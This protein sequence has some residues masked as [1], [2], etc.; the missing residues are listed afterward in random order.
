MHGETLPAAAN[1][2]GVRRTEL[3]TPLRI[4]GDGNCAGRRRPRG[5]IRLASTCGRAR[6]V[7]HLTEEWEWVSL[8][9]TRGEGA[10][11]AGQ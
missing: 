11:S 3:L 5:L 4:L 2:E 1:E 10:A 9:A 6:D 8:A 7:G